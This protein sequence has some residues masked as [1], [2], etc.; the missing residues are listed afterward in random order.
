M[1]PDC[2]DVVTT[3]IWTIGGRFDCR[4]NHQWDWSDRTHARADRG[5]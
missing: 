3:W 2:T 5:L 4:P 1:R